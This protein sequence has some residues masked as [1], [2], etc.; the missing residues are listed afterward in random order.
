MKPSGKAGEKS[1]EVEEELV[2]MSKFQLDLIIFLFSLPR[3]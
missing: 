1:G 2:E 3:H